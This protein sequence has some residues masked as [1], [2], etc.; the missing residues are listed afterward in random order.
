MDT[1]KI[2]IDKIRC[3]QPYMFYACWLVI[4]G[5]MTLSIMLDW[6][7]SKY[8]KLIDPIG[9][10]GFGGIFIMIIGSFGTIP[11]KK[12]FLCNVYDCVAK[13]FKKLLIY[14]LIIVL[15]SS[16]VGI[17]INPYITNGT[18]HFPQL[19]ILGYILIIC[20]FFVAKKMA[21][22]ILEKYT[23]KIIVLCVDVILLQKRYI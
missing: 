17:N 10:M 3:Y 14:E 5:W 7:H 13:H 2:C 16:G 1:D 18:S 8:Q 23:G 19:G 15:I 12:I 22:L 9:L 20:S 11:G 21:K 4:L 6:G